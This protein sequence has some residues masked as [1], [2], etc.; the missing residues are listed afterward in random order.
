M[1]AFI[2]AKKNEREVEEK[3]QQV[4]AAKRRAQAEDETVDALLARKRREV[5]AK[6]L[7]E[8][9]EEI[10]RRKQVDEAKVRQ[11][12]MKVFARATKASEQSAAARDTTED[13]P[14]KR[15][16]Y[17]R[18][19]GLMR[20]ELGVPGTGKRCTVATSLADLQVE[21]GVMN[22]QVDLERAS[23]MP[24][25]VLYRTIQAL[26]EAALPLGADCR[27]TADV[28]YER[29][30]RSK[31][32]ESVAE[33]H[34]ARAMKQ[35]SI[36]YSGYFASSPEMYMLM[37]IAEVAREQHKKNRNQSF[38]RGEAEAPADIAAAFDAAMATAGRRRAAVVD[39]EDDD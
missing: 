28:F 13:T 11:E 27:G 15:E 18:L 22:R 24:E 17:L 5:Q 4:A 20:E 7:L 10:E 39:E 26:E 2:E 32:A 9:E 34:M 3:Q 8:Q 29:L 23:E 16:E 35:L 19:I 37:Q 21:Y 33:R 12:Q 30:Q 31:V 6:K 38:E 36:K 1:D 14:E 25:I